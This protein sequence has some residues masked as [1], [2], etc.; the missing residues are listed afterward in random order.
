MSRGKT[1]LEIKVAQLNEMSRQIQWL[2]HKAQSGKEKDVQK[3]QAW[4]KKNRDRYEKI[5]REVE[6]LTEHYAEWGL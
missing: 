6:R 4:E 5:Q 3:M 2:Q 1:Y